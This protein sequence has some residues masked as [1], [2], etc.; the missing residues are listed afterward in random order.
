MRALT[1]CRRNGCAP[2][3]HGCLRPNRHREARAQMRQVT[4]DR[5][6]VVSKAPSELTIDSESLRSSRGI[7]GQTADTLVTT[8]G[9]MDPQQAVAERETIKLRPFAAALLAD[10]EIDVR[11]RHL[12]LDALVFLDQINGDASLLRRLLT[13]LVGEALRRAP[14]GTNIA[15]V[16]S[17]LVALAEFRITDEGAGRTA[18]VRDR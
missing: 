11:A 6:T 17:P 9:G 5:P 2:N 14:T 13:D 7:Y 4:L 16:V 1:S 12:T 3:R 8:L 15:V 10:F 18:G